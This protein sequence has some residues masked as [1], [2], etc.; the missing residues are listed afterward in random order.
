MKNLP[1]YTC[2][3]TTTSI[4]IA[5]IFTGAHDTEDSGHEDG[6]A[7]HAGGDEPLREQVLVS[8]FMGLIIGFFGFSCFLSHTH[9]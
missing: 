1:S 4:V 9:W 7:D 5:N 6:N 2:C 3:W 8:N